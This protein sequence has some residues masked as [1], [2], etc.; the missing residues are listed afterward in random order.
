MMCRRVPKPGRDRLRQE[1]GQRGISD[2]M[3]RPSIESED[4]G[5]LIADLT[6]ALDG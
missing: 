1:R 4:A 2:G 6:H 3:T 5:D